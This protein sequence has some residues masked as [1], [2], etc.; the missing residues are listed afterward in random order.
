MC[1]AQSSVATKSKPVM[2][3]IHGRMQTFYQSQRSSKDP[4]KVSVQDVRNP[5]KTEYGD[6]CRNYPNL[7]RYYRNLRRNLRMMWFA[8][9]HLSKTTF[10]D[11]DWQASWNANNLFETAP[12]WPNHFN[13]LEILEWEINQN[14]WPM[15][16]QTPN[17]SFQ[18]EF[19]K[20]R[21]KNEKCHSQTSYAVVWVKATFC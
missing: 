9:V 1:V 3:M 10:L 7:R 11:S 21:W 13:W 6:L 15:W 18:V 8:C 17:N 20:C 12:V 16:C 2:P 4:S 5:W 19:Q 14:L